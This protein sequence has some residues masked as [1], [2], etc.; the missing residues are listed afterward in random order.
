M[1]REHSTPTG[2]PSPVEPVLGAFSKVTYK[3]SSRPIFRRKIGGTIPKSG[4][5]IAKNAPFVPLFRHTPPGKPAC[6]CLV[7]NHLRDLSACRFSGKIGGLPPFCTL[8]GQTLASSPVVPP[9]KKGGQLDAAGAARAWSKK[10]RK[11]IFFGRD[12]RAENHPRR[13]GFR[14]PKTGPGSTSPPRGRISRSDG[15]APAASRGGSGST[16]PPFSG[17]AKA[18]G[19]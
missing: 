7:K 12:F 6:R 19:E 3:S 13:R 9:S 4:Y 14:V 2:T 8:G 16:G 18:A 15:H 10:L 5:K 1:W 11:C 17:A